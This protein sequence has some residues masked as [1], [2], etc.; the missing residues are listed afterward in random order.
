MLLYNIFINNIIYLYY[1]LKYI[2]NKNR[3]PVILIDVLTAHK[4][5][6]FNK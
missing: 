2:Y 1:K 6:N 5:N 3:S 4:I